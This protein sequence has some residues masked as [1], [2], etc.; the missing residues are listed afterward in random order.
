MLWPRKSSKQDLQDDESRLSVR[1]YLNSW[2]QHE[3][4]IAV[5]EVVSWQ[6][7][8]KH[9]TPL[10]GED[11]VTR[12]R[13]NEEMTVRWQ[14]FFSF[15]FSG[16]YANTAVLLWPP[17]GSRSL[18]SRQR[19]NPHCSSITRGRR[20]S[21]GVSESQHAAG[22]SWFSW[23]VH[24]DRGLIMQDSSTSKSLSPDVDE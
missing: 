11:D 14:V 18:S 12:V 15:F 1:R 23:L 6:H 21:S 10:Y 9:L 20:A 13:W 19:R 7:A 17:P 8:D 16:L 24:A 3:H 5:G 22:F 4:G 2:F